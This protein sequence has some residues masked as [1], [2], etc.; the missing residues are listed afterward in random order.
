MKKINF[1]S[2]ECRSESSKALLFLSRHIS[3]IKHE[4]IAFHITFLLEEALLLQQAN[5]SETLQ[6]ITQCIPTMQK[7]KDHNSLAYSQ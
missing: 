4:G 1:N 3:H 7:I 5:S 2:I 6:G